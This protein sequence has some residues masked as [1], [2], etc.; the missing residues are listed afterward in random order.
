MIATSPYERLAALGL[1]LPTAPSPIG[2]FVNAVE[3]ERLVYISGQGPLTA[4]GHLYTGKVGRD[5]TLEA[6]YA[7]ARLT[8][9]NLIGV[10]HAAI[11]DLAR[12]KRVVKLLGFVN[13]TETFTQHPAVINGC[14]D[15]LCEVFGAI[16]PHARS[17]IGVASLP[18]NISV[19]VEAIIECAP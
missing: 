2:H 8:G 17:A 14:S 1:T 9:L 15:L 7:H 5:V 4:D 3:S 10:L 18:N 19:E 6:A 11:G 13:A 12:V 16:G